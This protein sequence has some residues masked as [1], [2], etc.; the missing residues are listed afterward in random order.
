MSRALFLWEG[1]GQARGADQT[2]SLE[3]LQWLKKQACGHTEQQ[4]FRRGLPGLEHVKCKERIYKEPGASSCASGLMRLK[5]VKEKFHSDD[6]AATVFFPPGP[7]GKGEEARYPGALPV[8]TDSLDLHPWQPA[9]GPGSREFA[10]SFQEVI[11]T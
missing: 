6:S 8:L 2:S 7:A 9:L 5:S 4:P 3:S 1:W 11:P 10:P